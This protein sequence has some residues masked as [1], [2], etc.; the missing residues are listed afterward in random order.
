MKAQTMLSFLAFV[1][2]NGG[3]GGKAP[4]EPDTGTTNDS[5]TQNNADTGAGTDTATATDTD[6]DTGTATMDQDTSDTG[7]VAEVDPLAMQVGDEWTV[8]LSANASTGYEWTLQSGTDGSILELVS[9][10]YQDADDAEGVGS[11]GT[12]VF[13]FQAVGIGTTSI[14]IYYQRSWE[15]DAPADQYEQEIVVVE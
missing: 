4:V 1:A 8:R 5:G 3:C 15:C 9:S 6:K 14:L 10:E 7:V 12:Q 13:V 2:L 11:D